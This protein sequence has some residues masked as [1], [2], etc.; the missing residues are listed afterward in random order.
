MDA[1]AFQPADLL[2]PLNAFE[3]KFAPKELYVCGAIGHLARGP[4]VSVVGSRKASQDGIARAQQLCRML[5]KQDVTIVSGL[6]EGIDRAA[7]EAALESGG[8]TIGVLGTPLDRFYP[9]SNRDLQLQMMREQLV[10]SQFAEGTKTAP[11]HFPLRNRLMA[12]IADATVIVEAGESS[13]TLSQGWESLRIGRPLFLLE[14]VASNS[15]LTWPNEMMRYGAKVL[16]RTNLDELFEELPLRSNEEL[17]DAL[18][19]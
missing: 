3:Q 6:A 17:I 19:F 8:R 9:A 2:G 10:V 12:L 16:S 4:R 1:R 14:S 18:V 7:H 11:W 13:G 5:S 15:T